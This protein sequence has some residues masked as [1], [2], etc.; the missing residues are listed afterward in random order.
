[1]QCLKSN[2]FAMAMVGPEGSVGRNAGGFNED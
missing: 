2:E 1:M